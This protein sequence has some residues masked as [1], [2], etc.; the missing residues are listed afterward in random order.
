MTERDRQHCEVTL[1]VLRLDL[2]SPNP[3]TGQSIYSENSKEAMF[4]C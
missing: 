2:R 3:R 4:N 1:L